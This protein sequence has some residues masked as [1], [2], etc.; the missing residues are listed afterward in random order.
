MND[1]RFK[2]RAKDGQIIM[3][4]DTLQEAQRAAILNSLRYPVVEDSD[5]TVVARVAFKS[6]E[7]LDDA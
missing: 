1:K 5:G 6:D 4:Y 3:S 2:V 7:Q